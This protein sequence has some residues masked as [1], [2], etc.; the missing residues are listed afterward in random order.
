MQPKRFLTLSMVG[1]LHLSL[2]LRRCFHCWACSYT[3]P[4][5]SIKAVQGIPT[6]LC[7]L[8]IVFAFVMKGSPEHHCSLFRRL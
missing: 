4:L 1:I 8:C 2:T 3:L 6:W 7:T 5:L